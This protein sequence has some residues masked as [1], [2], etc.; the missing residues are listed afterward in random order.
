MFL[1]KR[2]EEEHEM[3]ITNL[4]QSSLCRLIWAKTQSNYVHMTMMVMMLEIISRNWLTRTKLPLTIRESEDN[5]VVDPSAILCFQSNFGMKST[6]TMDRKRFL[7]SSLC[8][9]KDNPNQTEI[10]IDF[11]FFSS[12]RQCSCCWSVFMFHWRLDTL[13]AFSAI[14]SPHNFSL[15]L[16]TNSFVFI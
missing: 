4:L 5:I 16:V 2:G 6:K 10:E 13:N 12:V 3:E 8:F 1:I 9:G 7:S 15:S 11:R 14:L